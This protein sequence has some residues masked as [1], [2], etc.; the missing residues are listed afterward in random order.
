MNF[1]T[2]L[3][4]ISSSTK[5]RSIA[6]QVRRRS[7]TVSCTPQQSTSSQPIRGKANALSECIALTGEGRAWHGLTGSAACRWLMEAAASSES[8]GSDTMELQDR[9]QVRSSLLDLGAL[10]A[11]Y[12]HAAEQMAWQHSPPINVM[13]C[14]GPVMPVLWSYRSCVVMWCCTTSDQG[15]KHGRSSLT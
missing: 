8:H 10:R 9:Y 15:S 7:S 5:Q 13:V 12:V 6:L 1:Q 4:P 11:E 2:L 14:A 3:L